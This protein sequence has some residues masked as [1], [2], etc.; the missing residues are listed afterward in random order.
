MHS[1]EHKQISSR[2]LVPPLS[3]EYPWFVA[4]NLEA[5]ED[6]AQAHTFFNLHDPLSHYRCKI[7]ELLGKRIRGCFFGCWVL[8]SNRDNRWSLW[9]PI[10]CE[11][12][13]LP[14]LNH[15]EKEGYYDDI[16]HCCL[17]APPDHPSSVLLLT[18]TNKRSLVYCRLGS[19]SSFPNTLRKEELRWT[20]M[21]YAKQV[22]SITGFDDGYLYSVTCCNDRVYAYL[23]V[24][25]A[26]IHTLVVEIKMMVKYRKRKKLRQVVITLLPILEFPYPTSVDC[27]AAL[28]FLEGSGTELF[29]IGIGIKDE[30]SFSIGDVKLFKLNMNSKVWEEIDDLKET[31]ISIQL[32][33]DTSPLFATRTIVSSESGGYIHILGDKGNIVYSYHV[34]DQ[35]IS[36]SSIPYVAETNHMSSWA[37]LECTRLEDDHAHLK[38]EKD[39]G[40]EI[41]VKGDHKVEINNTKDGSHLLNFTFHVLKMI[42]EFCAGFDCLPLSCVGYESSGRVYAYL[43]VPEA[44]IRTLLVEIKMMVKYR[45]RKKLRQVVITFLPILE[46]PYPI[47]LGCVA[48]NFLEGS[49]TELFT[50]G[51]AIKD[52]TSFSVVDVKLF[53]LNMNSKVWE[54]VDDLKETI[55]FVELSTD[56]TPIF[57]TH[58]IGSSESG[59]YIHVLS[60]KGNIVYSYHVKDQTISVSSIPCV[61]ETNHM[62]SWAMLECTRLEDESPLLNI[63]LHVL[64]IVMEFCVGVEYLKFRSTCKLCH[65]AAPLIQ[66]K[67][68]KALEKYSLLSP[69]LMVFD[70]HKGIITFTD[71]M[72]GDK[73]FIKTPQD[74]IG[75]YFEIKCSRY[76][77]LLI[78]T[79]DNTMLLFNPFTSDIRKLPE[80]HSTDIYSFSAPPTSPDCMVVALTRRC[81]FIHFVAAG[82]P[83]W[84]R[85]VLDFEGD[86]YQFFTLNG[87]ESLDLYAMKANGGLDIYKDMG[88]E[89]YYWERTLCPAPTSCC[90]SFRQS[91]LVRCEER[92]FL[93]V[94]LGQFGESVEVFKLNDTTHEWV[95]ID[96]LGKHMIFISSA[97]PICIEAKIPEMEN[98]I[99]FPRLSS[100]KGNIVFYSLETCRY[101]TFNNKHIQENFG[102]FFGTRYLATPHA[103]IEPNWR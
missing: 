70:K 102:D 89:Y 14:P 12:I 73:Y 53:K 83:S 11:I 29:T 34:K 7:P 74:L 2:S 81:V 40:D 18:R 35:T 32:S 36:V 96:S 87:L 31:I 86:D 47:I 28:N 103:W 60:D 63:P 6:D 72:F 55:I 80:V 23:K 17:S 97:S 95:K 68:G 10:T 38:Q 84:R 48:L 71:P 33:T 46:F 49:S 99:F 85:V 1:L 75:E 67:N 88:G 93:Q 69:W 4:Q 42:K 39:K 44:R 62:S 41:V 57:A 13:N 94:I 52:K 90:T 64:E 77:W 91:F 15:R 101:H 51:I 26:R 59:G 61:A 19:D 50:I 56:S 54:E 30:T 20:E 78:L 98:K 37:M 3:P 45:K 58:T 82:E 9:N 79:D 65:L 5:E 24:P 21:T 8:L 25:E 100:P 43:K 16:R 27:Y 92:G 76:G 22:R 66:C